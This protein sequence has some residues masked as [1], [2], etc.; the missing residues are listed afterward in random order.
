MTPARFHP[1]DRLPNGAIVIAASTNKAN[2]WIVLAMRPDAPFDQYVTWE[3]N[4]P[5][6]G[7]DTRWGHYHTSLRAAVEDYYN[8]AGIV[9]VA[10]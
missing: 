9:L 1:G 7:T 8:R 10:A 6:D 5:G 2:V 4:R 3:C